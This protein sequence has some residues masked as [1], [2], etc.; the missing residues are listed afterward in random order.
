ML[1]S[2]PSHTAAH[3]LLLLVRVINLN[4]NNVFL[5]CYPGADKQT[6]LLKRCCAV[7]NVRVQ[8]VEV[9]GKAWR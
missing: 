7:R 1:G 9:K 2:L 8:R 3:T 5:V 6:Q 4:E